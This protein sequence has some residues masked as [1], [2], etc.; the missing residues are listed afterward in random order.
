MPHT[1]QNSRRGS[2]YSRGIGASELAPGDQVLG[3]SPPGMQGIRGD[4]CSGQV[5][6]V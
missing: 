1:S 6:V 2:S 3:M 4:D 5:D